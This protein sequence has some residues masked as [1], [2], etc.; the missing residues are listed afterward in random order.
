MHKRYVFLF[1]LLA[2][3]LHAQEDS[4][5]YY[6]NDKGLSRFDR[7]VKT[8]LT[9][10]LKGN[11]MCIVEKDISGNFRLEYGGGLLTGALVEPVL[12]P[13]YRQGTDLFDEGFDRVK[14]KPGF[15]LYA[16]PRYTDVKFP[17]W[18]VSSSLL[19]KYYIGQL[20]VV[21]LS[22]SLGYEFNLNKRW[23]VDIS[24]GIG[25]DVLFSSDGYYYVHKHRF[26][27]AKGFE[28]PMSWA[29]YIPLSIKLGYRIP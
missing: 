5:A 2:F 29:Y 4:I 14:M 7:V 15:S 16:S 23:V 19:V 1:F 18:Y 9:Q 13:M 17:W 21:D 10:L 11:L 20:S 26:F 12:D 25:G 3:K 6:L 8:D 28:T 22:F 27:T 24:S